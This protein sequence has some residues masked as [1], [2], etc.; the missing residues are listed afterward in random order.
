MS[1]RKMI[2][3]VAGVGM[4]VLAGLGVALAD[5]PMQSLRAG[6]LALKAPAAW[7]SEKPKSAM[8]QLQVKVPA[9]PGDSE[10]GEM[11]V[12]AFPGGAGSKEANIKRWEEM[13]VDG[14]KNTAKAKVEER[15]G[16]NVPVTRIEI[17]GRYVATAMPGAGGPKADNPNYRLLGA[18]VETKTTGYFFKLVG[19]DKTL[20][21]ASKG[22]DDMIASMTLED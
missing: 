20:K 12:F 1:F 11:T 13:F 9:A 15:K 7:K 3:M 14:E 2:P 21:A 19:P 8:R 4:V 5:E 6:S 18:I 16:A 10:P 17:A 22:F